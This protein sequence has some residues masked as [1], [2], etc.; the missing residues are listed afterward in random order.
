[1]IYY[2]NYTT[3][4]YCLRSHSPLP[5]HSLIPLHFP[6]KSAHSTT[7][8]TH[9]EG[10]THGEG[11]CVVKG[12]HTAA[13]MAKGGHTAAGM[14]KGGHAAAGM[15]KGGHVASGRCDRVT[16][17]RW[18]GEGDTWQW[19]DTAKATG[20]GEGDM[21]R[22]QCETEGAGDQREGNGQH[23]KKKKK[24]R[25]TRCLQRR[26]TRLWAERVRQWYAK[27]PLCAQHRQRNLH[28]GS[29]D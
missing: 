29:T 5:T 22:R 9:G 26:A 1:M 20:W 12:W 16:Q 10:G 3:L 18:H 24:K 21:W 13:G 2:M 14:A 23:L 6:H 11:W 7:R 4:H 19:G 25:C 27:P 17:R 15:A 28:P 8:V